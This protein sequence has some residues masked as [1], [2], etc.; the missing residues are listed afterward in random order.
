M[1][2]N[3]KTRTPKEK[4]LLTRVQRCVEGYGLCMEGKTDKTDLLLMGKFFI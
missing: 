4:I 3:N 1:S 2:P